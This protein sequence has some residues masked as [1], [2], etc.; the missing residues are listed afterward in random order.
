MHLEMLDIKLEEGIIA[1]RLQVQPISLAQ[2]KSSE[3]PSAFST[4]LAGRCR[5]AQCWK[6]GSAQDKTLP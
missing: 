3:M 2:P 1:G 5:G 4:P 6:R